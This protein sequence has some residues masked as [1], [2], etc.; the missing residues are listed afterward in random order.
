MKKWNRAVMSVMAATLLTATPA[1]AAQAEKTSASHT[2]VAVDAT[3]QALAQ[4]TIDKLSELLP[5]MKELTVQKM[6]IGETSDVVM[7]ERKK[8]DG[9]KTPRMV[10]FLD[11]KTGDINSFGYRTDEPDDKELPLDVQKEKADAFLKALLGDAAK[12][13]QYNPQKSE[14]LGGPA[15]RLVING[16]PHHDEKMSLG[17]NGNGEV[18]SLIS[19]VGQISKQI[20]PASLPKPEEAMSLEE[21]EKAVAGLMTPVYR[22]NKDRTGLMLTYQVSWSGFLDAKSGKSV[23]TEHARF[24]HEPNLSAP[25]IPVSPKGQKL[26]AKDKDEAASHLKNLIGFDTT[27]ATFTEMVPKNVPNGDRKEFQWKKGDQVAT[28][29]VKTTNGQ[30]VALYLE[31]DSKELSKK[32]SIEEAQKTALQVLQTYLHT[33]T[34]AVTMD[35]DFRL[36]QFDYYIFNFFNTINGIP[37]EDQSYRVEINSETGKLMGLFGE[38]DPSAVTYPDPAKAVS[39]EKAA[40]EYLKHHPLELMYYAPVIDRESSESTILVYKPQE[41]DYMLEYVDALTGESIQNPRKKK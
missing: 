36:K 4:K 19:N 22:S 34:K 23:E 31:D 18:V 16:V 33:D 27:G 39:P 32:V 1:W 24:Y 9:K 37:V 8:G 15:Y 41:N 20:D 35:K 11:K 26:I 2:G 3:A 21:A 5:Y 25:A 29:Q 13:Y 30:V 14:Q 40:K 38:F 28:V 10:I 6:D 7:V 17:L 12:M